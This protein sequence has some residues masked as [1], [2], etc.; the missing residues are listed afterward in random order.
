M[1][2][3]IKEAFENLKMSNE[4]AEMITAKLNNTDIHPRSGRF[5]PI[6]IAACLLLVI[7]VFTNS[8]AVAALETVGES[9]KAAVTELL[10]PNAPVTEQ[11]KTENGI[12]KIQTVTNENGKEEQHI[13]QYS[14]VDEPEFLKVE[15]D[16]L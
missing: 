2:K 15:S 10:I 1:E 16:G 6:A 14:N 11:Y 5:A 8:T 13:A 3:Q 7:F 12:I 4:C 9:I